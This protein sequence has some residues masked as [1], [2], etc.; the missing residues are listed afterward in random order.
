MDIRC[1]ICTEPWDNDCLHDRAEELGH[2]CDGIRPDSPC[3]DGCVKY[4]EVARDFRV[5]GCE[6]LGTDHGD[7][8][9]E[10]GGVASAIYDLMGDDMDGA[11]SA[12]EDAEMLGLL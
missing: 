1:P 3:A 2:R 4:T 8:R 12:F 11:A 9:P 5:R 6:A 10:N 7:M